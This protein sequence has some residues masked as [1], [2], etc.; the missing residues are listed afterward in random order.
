MLYVRYVYRYRSFARCVHFVRI[1]VC[2]LE[3][4]GYRP[5]VLVPLEIAGLVSSFE[6]SCPKPRWTIGNNGRGVFS[7]QQY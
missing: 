3:A 1:A 4:C 6:A 7:H 5:N 2:P